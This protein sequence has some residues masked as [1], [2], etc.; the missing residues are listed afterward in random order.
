MPYSGEFLDYIFL[1]FLKHN[2]HQI[3]TVLDIGPGAG[4]YGRLVRSILPQANIR[5]VEIE[6]SYFTRF[7]KEY[8]EFYNVVDQ[9]DAMALLNEHEE[10]YDLVILGDVIEHMRKSDGVDFLNFFIYRSKFIYIQ[11]PEYYIQYPSNVDGVV[12][13]SHVSVWTSL[14]FA[15]FGRHEFRKAPLVATLVDGYINHEI[16]EANSWQNWCRSSKS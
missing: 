1:E 3:N 15:N 13:E 11:Y 12:S 14:D 7:L 16:V 9:A 4:K 8:N 5:G 10:K 6:P 2:K